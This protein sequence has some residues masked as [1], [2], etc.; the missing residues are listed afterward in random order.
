MSNL[1]PFE[2]FVIRVPNKSIEALGSNDMKSLSDYINCVM[3]NKDL[4]L[5]IYLAS[6][7]LYNE[8]MKLGVFEKGIVSAKKLRAVSVSLFNY[9]SRMSMRATPF[10]N[11]SSVGQGHIASSNNLEDQFIYKN[12]HSFSLEYTEVILREIVNF[13]LTTPHLKNIVIYYT[14]NTMYQYGRNLRYIEFLDTESTRKYSISEIKYNSFLVKLLEYC[15]NGKT[16]NSICQYIQNKGYSLDETEKFL[17]QLIDNKVLYSE[18]EPSTSTQTYHQQIYNFLKKN[19]IHKNSILLNL[20]EELQNVSIDSICPEQLNDIADKFKSINVKN[21]NCCF[22]YDSL[23]SQD[24]IIDKETFDKVRDGFNLYLSFCVEKKPSSRNISKWKKA[25]EFRF[26]SEF[27]NIKEAFDQDS[28]VYFNDNIHTDAFDINPFIDDIYI[29]KENS[30]NS[31]LALDNINKYILNETK[32]VFAGTCEYINLPRSLFDKKLNESSLPLTLNAYCQIGKNSDSRTIIN[33]LESLSDSA[34]CMLSRFGARNEKINEICNNLAKWEQEKMKHGTVAELNHTP[35][36]NSVNILGRQINRDYTISLLTNPDTGKSDNVSLDDLY[37]GIYED[38]IVLYDIKR[39]REV[40]PILSHTQNYNIELLPIYKFLAEVQ[41]NNCNNNRYFHRSASFLL[42][43]FEFQPRIMCE[44]YCFSLAKWK[45]SC[46][47]LRP[48]FQMEFKA[49]II[50]LEKFLRE[51]GIPS[52]FS[53]IKGDQKLYID[54]DKTP[55]KAL[56]TLEYECHNKSYILIEEVFYSQYES[57]LKD[58]RSESY[59]AEYLFPFKN[60]GVI[61]NTNSIID[62]KYIYTA[63]CSSKPRTFF[64]LQSEWL[65]IKLYAGANVIDRIISN[66]LNNIESETKKLINSWHF[67]RYKDMI[68][69]HIRLRYHIK[70]VSPKKTESL[71]GVIQ[72]NISHYA[73]NEIFLITY[74][75]FE[76]ELER[77]GIDNI[78]TIEKIFCID[79]NLHCVMLSSLTNNTKRFYFGLCVIITYLKIFF[80]GN[81]L[82]KISFISRRINDFNNEFPTTKETRIKLNKKFHSNIKEFDIYCEEVKDRFD[83]FENRVLSAI[84]KNNALPSETYSSI[85]H[86][87]LVRLYKSRNR[88]NEYVA[89]QMLERYFKRATFIDKSNLGRANE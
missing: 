17:N 35:N 41:L 88:L 71:I 22:S 14:N 27:I 77:Y 65:Y 68:G 6:P 34:T 40:F 74:D 19:K 66:D 73:T 80:G 7:H 25:F 47:D 84:T 18:L 26:G 58:S 29:R 38:R 59:A 23:I 64:P 55:H 72:K 33:F 45:I 70:D 89:Y 11:F 2:N 44:D 85:I 63:L 15:K 36:I 46:D 42:D 51:K 24:V 30:I 21:I 13:I 67:I 81:I 31:N 37:I 56:I 82:N 54:V 79:S 4:M 57:I 48:I 61:K 76:K 62:N 43:Y 12:E 53:I 5:G 9:N 69:S 10:G 49:R 87:S 83:D 1:L 28:G 3:Q 8:I 50:S 20:F 16:Y 32:K 39:Q 78:H 52:Q 86:M 75:T 60:D